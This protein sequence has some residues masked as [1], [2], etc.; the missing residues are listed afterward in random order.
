MLVANYQ[1][2]DSQPKSLSV[3][4]E[5]LQPVSRYYVSVPLCRRAVQQAVSE[6]SDDC[7]V[8]YVLN[9]AAL[10][11]PHA[12]N[13]LAADLA[14]YNADVAI[15]TETHFKTKHSDSIVSIPGYTL[16]R[17]DRIGR[18]GGGV[19]LYMRST[20]QWASWK[21]DADNRTFELHWVRIGNTYVGALYHPP[22][23][24][25]SMDSLLQY[26]ESCVA[27]IL[28]QS[29]AASVILAGDLNQLSDTAI[30]LSL[31]HI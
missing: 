7:A 26:V 28:R 6:T 14:S 9:A 20:L 29:P 15:L 4:T 24:L 31:I 17:R 2:N 22:R 16:S 1:P 18:R 23:P 25:Y 27:N 13:Q 19:A 8:L 30:E 21:Y 10:S 11:K 12:I 3:I 5:R